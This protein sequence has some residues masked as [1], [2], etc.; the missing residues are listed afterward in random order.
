MT[1]PRE[2]KENLWFVVEGGSEPAEERVKPSVEDVARAMYADDIRQGRVLLAWEA[3]PEDEQRWYLSNARAAL[4]LFPAR[5]EA[6]VK[7]EALREWIAEWP[8]APSDGTFLADVARNGLERAAC[9]ARGE[10]RR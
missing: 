5:T 9:I 8:T 4:A 6:E 7:A 1:D 2:A 3:V 10:P